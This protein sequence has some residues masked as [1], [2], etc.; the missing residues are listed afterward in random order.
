M[1][2]SVLHSL[3]PLRLELQRLLQLP[4]GLLLLLQPLLD[5]GWRKKIARLVST[6]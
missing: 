4:L 5:G 3:P 6:M 2:Q 1:F